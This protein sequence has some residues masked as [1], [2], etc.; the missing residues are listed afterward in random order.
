MLDDADRNAIETAVRDAETRTCGEIYCVAAEESSDYR[1]VVL[2]WAGGVAILAPALLL[3]AGIEVSVPDLIGGWTAAQVGAAAETAAREAL[4]GAVLLQGLLF[5]VTAIVVALPAVRLFA[6]PRWLKR[7]QVRRR[8]SEQ[9]LAKNLHLTR[10]RTGVLIYVSLKERMA[11][12]L[13]DEGIAAKV[14]PAAWDEAMRA[15]TDGLRRGR[16]G[17]GFTAAIVR[18]GDL[19]AQHFPADAADNPNELPDA[20]VILPKT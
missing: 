19:L 3:L 2:A 18:C 11:E 17:E 5:V 8:A 7:E 15:L 10:G 4:I 13:A 12:I 14:E 20:L 6:A 1:E 16:A 9:F